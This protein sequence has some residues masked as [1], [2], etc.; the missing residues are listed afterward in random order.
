MKS[1]FRLKSIACGEHGL[2]PG[3]FE[4]TLGFTSFRK[5][6]HSTLYMNSFV[7][8]TQKIHLLVIANCEGQ[9][10]KEYGSS[11][12]AFKKFRE[13]RTWRLSNNPTVATIPKTGDMEILDDLML[14]ASR[15]V[16]S[17]VS[18]LCSSPL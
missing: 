3:K 6:S 9:I 10:I 13:A 11:L 17:K 18:A 2:F 5:R 1:F 14:N 16:Y 7:S 8:K 15:S 4:A 12:R